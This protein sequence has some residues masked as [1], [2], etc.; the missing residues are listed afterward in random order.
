MIQIRIGRLMLRNWH[1]YLWRQRR[2][3]KNP[4]VHW[5]QWDRI[6]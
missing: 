3:V 2:A 5:M 1:L 6:V 4:K